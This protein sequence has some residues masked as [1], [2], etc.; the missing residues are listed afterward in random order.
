MRNAEGDPIWFVIWIRHHRVLAEVRE[1][2]CM[3]VFDSAR[4]YV[5]SQDVARLAMI[6]ELPVPT[7][8]VVPQQETGSEECG[9]FVCAYMAMR[10]A[11]REIPA[12][13]A[14]ISMRPVVDAYE[15]GVEAMRAV[16]YQTLRV[17]RERDVVA[18]E[19][20]TGD[21]VLVKWRSDGESELHEEKAVCLDNAGGGRGI[22]SFC[23]DRGSLL[24]RMSGTAR[25]AYPM[26]IRRDF[27]IEAVSCADA[28]D[29]APRSPPP[30]L[31]TVPHP[32]AVPDTNVAVRGVPG[33]RR[34]TRLVRRA[35][36]VGSYGAAVL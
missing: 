29:H 13:S 5:V 14:K 36:S 8:P 26:R 22:I 15:D 6:L 10:R 21:M 16:A 1:H 17:V 4:S 35:G 12:T 25:W 3:Y 31:T 2:Q 23:M 20:R 33:S 24:K 32:A 11:A 19:P 28:V 34:T 7:F 18:G 27:V 9:V 30:E